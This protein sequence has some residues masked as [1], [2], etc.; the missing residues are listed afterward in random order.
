MVKKCQLCEMLWG[1]HIAQS[2]IN[3]K[4]TKDK[5]WENEYNVK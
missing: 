2:M 1:V 3:T 4:D 5:K